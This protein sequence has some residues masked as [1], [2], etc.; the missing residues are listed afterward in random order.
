M[1]RLVRSSRFQVTFLALLFL[2]LF[3]SHPPADPDVFHRVAVGR[4]VEATGGVVDQDPFAFTRKHDRWIDHEWLSGVVFYHAVRWWGDWGLLAVTLVTLLATLALAS[5][6]QQIHQGG[7][8]GTFAWLLLTGFVTAR[9]WGSM[10]RSQSFTFALL[11]FQLLAVV[12]WRAGRPRLLWLLPLAYVPWANLHGGF[13]AG[14][15]L[16]GVSAAAVTLERGRSARGLWLC[17]G[18]SALL[19]VVNPWGI[20]Y[21][22]YIATAVTMARP[23]IGEWGALDLGSFWGVLALLLAAVFVAGA[24]RARPRPPPE[25]WA[26]VAA[27]LAAALSSERFLAIFVLTLAVY[28]TPSARALLRPLVARLPVGGRF[29][30]PLRTAGLA[31]M[32]GTVAWQAV[33]RVSAFARDGLDFARYPVAAVAWLET[34]G[35]GNL[36]VHF[37]YGSYALWRLYPRY[38]VSVDG[39]YEEVYPQET[40]DRV[41]TALDPDAEG[42]AEALREVDP[43]Y[44][45]VDGDGAG[46]GPTWTP[47]YSDER[48]TILSRD[49]RPPAPDPDARVRP[50]WVPGF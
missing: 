42:H 18:A 28:G 45:L 3:A 16:L 23:N 1:S 9:A 35:G 38:R 7:G 6:A 33:L 37:N 26:V 21:W 30:S 13:V 14:L 46:F 11:A 5:R 41:M 8:A 50:M 43:D 36:L 15:G 39:R 12:R 40:V 27:S 22:R 24:W 20:A 25:G 2:A 4:L 47:V 32:V 49:G 29:P 44:I 31:M 34:R 10:A 19:T 48:V 17:L